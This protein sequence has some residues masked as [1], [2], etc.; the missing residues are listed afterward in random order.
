LADILGVPARW[1][2]TPEQVEANRAK[3]DQAAQLAQ[4]TQAAP[5]AAAVIKAL[6]PAGAA[7]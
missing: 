5:G 4:M 6:K 2:S 1:I 3:R 7:A